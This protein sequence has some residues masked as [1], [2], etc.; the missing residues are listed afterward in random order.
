MELTSKERI[1][2]AMNL[3]KP[4]R[5]P[6]MCQFSIGSMM[7]QLHPDPVAFWYD[8]NVFAEGLI[9]LCK[10]FRFD[11]ILVSLHGHYDNWK[12]KLVKSEQIDKENIKLTFENRTE[13]HSLTDLPLIIFN[14]SQIALD[15]EEIDIDKNIP[16]VIN[17][18]PVSSNLHFNLD[19]NNLFDIFD[20]IY[21]KVGGEYSI[22]GEITSPFDYLL[23]LL[24]YQNGLI[25]L[26]MA[27]EKCKTI[28]DKFADGILD[29]AI[30]MCDKHIDAIKIS[31][32]FAGMGF[33]STDQYREFVLPYE[34]RIINAIRKKGK[35]VYTH[36]CGSIADRL[37]LM[38]ES[39]TSGLECLDP[40]PLGNV[41]LEIA[42]EQIGN[43]LFIKG[44]IDSVNSL[45]YAD[46]EKAETDVRRIIEIGKTKGKGFILSTACSIAPMVTKERLFM[47]SRMVEKYGQY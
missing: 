12:D 13:V 31:S 17:Y 44:N 18:I 26:I 14:E 40:P 11:G 5:I 2:C 22:H 42:F 9:E 32:P 33:I 20:I 38:S 10:K 4:D 8:K 34:R 27:P 19:T 1:N 3:Q 41:D 25:S 7:N 16:S 15:I 35:H 28:L 30:K 46:D 21:Q 23:D 29:I 47:L 24:G 36:T 39:N 45:L 37:E 6:L 43:D